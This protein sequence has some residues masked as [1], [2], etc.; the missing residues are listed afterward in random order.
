MD[1]II[2]NCMAKTDREKI[3]EV[4]GKTEDHFEEK[5]TYL[6]AGSL[7]LSITFIEKI[8]PLE[9]AFAVF[10]LVI[11]WGLLILTL[12]LNLISHMISKYLLNK[13]LLERDKN[14]DSYSK[15]IKRNKRIDF[16]NWITVVL[17]ILGISS[18]VTFASINSYQKASK[19]NEKDQQNKTTL[20]SPNFTL[21]KSQ[22]NTYYYYGK[23][24]K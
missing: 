24:N 14:V 5:L 13:T 3:Q 6:S 9:D 15:V 2:D 7:V 1:E 4:I 12:L 8:I 18:I 21:N 16:I 10:F 17:L 11:G 22:L 19:Q 23:N 20:Q